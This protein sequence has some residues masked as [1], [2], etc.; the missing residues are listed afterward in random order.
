MGSGQRRCRLQP[1][2][3]LPAMPSSPDPIPARIFQI[4]GHR[5]ILDADL[6]RLYGVP[7]HVF[8]QAVK[9]NR[10]RFPD[11]FAF[12]LTAGE[13]TDLKSRSVTS[14][15]TET[16]SSQTVMSSA[17]LAD[18][19]G[20]KDN[21]P[22]IAFSSKA[23]HR[24]AAY[25]PWAFTEHGALMA[26]NILRSE[27][28]TEMS[29]YVVRAFVKQRETLATNAAILKRLADGARQRGA[30]VVKCNETARVSWTRVHLCGC[31]T[32]AA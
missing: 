21:W 25:R 26:A 15:S 11:D 31:P 16:N 12:R 6:A 1:I 29:V 2:S 20:D 9:R 27:R 4:R 19:P 24:G 5:V 3:T 14:R 30:G 23:K 22:Q 18:E 8:N 28:A 13:V 17:Q 10:H 32:R 7:T